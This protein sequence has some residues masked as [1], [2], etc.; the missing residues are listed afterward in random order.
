MYEGEL[1]EARKCLDE[2]DKEKSKLEIQVVS[3]Q[4]QLDELRQ[5]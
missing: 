5:R 1:A 2:G 4:E 3:L